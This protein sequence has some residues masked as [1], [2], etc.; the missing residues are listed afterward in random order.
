VKHPKRVYL[1][2]GNH[3]TKELTL[4]YGFYKECNKKYGSVNVWQH[5]VNTFD[6]MSLS[7]VISN[8]IFCVHGGLSPSIHTLD[9]I[10]SIPKKNLSDSASDLLWSDPSENKGWAK[11][12]R[13]LGFL[14]GPDV[15]KQ[16]NHNNNLDYIS[17]GHQLVMSGYLWNSNNTVLTIWS[18][19]NY[20]YRC[21]NVA[22]IAE[23]NGNLEL[24]M[25]TF[26]AAPVEERGAPFRVPAIF[27]VWIFSRHYS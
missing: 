8:R 19:P 6:Y 1:L 3:E 17:Q 11:S 2:R 25:R 27:L 9:E 14:F 4:R 26:E 22:A 7:A 13:G 16:F 23:F 10:K 5:F 12:P 18:A 24:N 15:A 20:C 21:G